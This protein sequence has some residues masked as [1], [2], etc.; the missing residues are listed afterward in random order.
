MHT[1][2][3]VVRNAQES[4]GGDEFASV[5]VFESVH[6]TETGADKALEKLQAEKPDDQFEI[7]ERRTED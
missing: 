6:Q 5:D 1:L 7:L 2:Y 3:I 4:V